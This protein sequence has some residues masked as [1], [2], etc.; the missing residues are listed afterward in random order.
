MYYLF[1]YN[2]LLSFGTFIKNYISKHG[3]SVFTIIIPFNNDYFEVSMEL[4]ILSDN[5]DKLADVFFRIDNNTSEDILIYKKNW[6]AGLC[7]FR[8]EHRYYISIW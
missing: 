3:N 1:L 4:N 6:Y 5:Y 7:L 2:A 8:E